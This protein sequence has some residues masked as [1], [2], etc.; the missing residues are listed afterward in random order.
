LLACVATIGIRVQ[1]ADRIALAAFEEAAAA[2]AALE[3]TAAAT[4]AAAAPAAAE[5][6]ALDAS[7]NAA[8]VQR[9]REAAAAGEVTPARARL[10]EAAA[11]LQNSDSA[12]ALGSVV[13]SATTAAAANASGDD[14]SV[15]AAAA[16]AAAAAAT[17]AAQKQYRAIQRK[18]DG[19]EALVGALQSAQ[20]EQA[21]AGQQLQAN[22]QLFNSAASSAA[23]AAAAAAAAV[24]VPVAPVAVYRDPEDA[25]VPLPASAVLE[26]VPL[27]SLPVQ[28]RSRL[29]FGEH[30]YT[31]LGLR[32]SVTV[33]V[34]RSLPPPPEHSTNA[35]RSSYWWDAAAKT[36]YV[37]ARRLGSS[38]DFGLVL[39]HAAAHLKSD[40]EPEHLQDDTRPAFTQHFHGALRTLTQELFARRTGPAD[41]TSSATVDE[42]KGRRT[43]VIVASKRGSVSTATTAANAAAAKEATAATATAA[44]GTNSVSAATLPQGFSEQALQQRIEMYAKASGLPQLSSFLDRY[45]SESKSGTG[46]DRK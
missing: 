36:L 32:D 3:R 21:A 19:I 7:I 31:V 22:V 26:V 13:H 37:H 27:D 41:S 29:E 42:L 15:A 6:I 24:P 17:A 12:T 9:A 33:A 5:G 45:A 8:A 23:A 28:A 14:A 16:T 4:A 18:L 46:R 35:F 43:S 25:A 1:Q 30:L 11:R 40:A 38:G 20:A 44:S 2:Q 39:V 34:A 10:Q